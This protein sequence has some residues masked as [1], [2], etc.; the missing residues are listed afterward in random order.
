MT[1]RLAGRYNEDTVT[2]DVEIPSQ[3]GRRDQSFNRV[4]SR[5]MKAFSSLTDQ[6][7]L[8]SASILAGSVD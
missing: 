3:M 8:R 2:A 6:L 7:S 4:S 5:K 1:V